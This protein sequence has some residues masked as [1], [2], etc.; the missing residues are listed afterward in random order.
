MDINQTAIRTL[1]G[2]PSNVYDL[3][4]KVL[5]KNHRDWLIGQVDIRRFAKRSVRESSI[6]PKV[7]ATNSVRRMGKGLF[8]YEYFNICFLNDV[9]QFMLNT[10]MEERLPEIGIKNSKGVNIWEMF[11][12]QPAEYMTIAE[13][14]GKDKGRIPDSNEMASRSKHSIEIMT[15]DNTRIFADF[16][17]IYSEEMVKLWGNVYRYFVR[18]N[19]STKSYIKKELSDIFERDRRVLGVLVRGTDYTNLRPTGHPVQPEVP[20]VIED[21][22]LLMESEGY[23]YIYLATEDGRIDKAFRDVFGDKLLINNRNYYDEI[24]NN[25]KIELIKDVHFDR[26]NDDYLKGVEYLSSIVILS[27]CD[28]LL[29]GNCGGSQ[30]AVFLNRLKYKKCNIYN[31]GLY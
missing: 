15:E 24:Y 10:V 3:V 16:N 30:A 28:S 20:R 13:C 31:L 19:D 1:S 18:F 23:E 12:K 17:D 2:L 25:Q 26:D 22:R 8:D 4:R 14:G 27:K 6:I 11:F 5:V 9:L 29:A 7:V 21:A